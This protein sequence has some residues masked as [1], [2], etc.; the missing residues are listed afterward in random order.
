MRTF[1]TSISREQWWHFNPPSAGQ[2]VLRTFH[3]SNDELGNRTQMRIC[4]ASHRIR[5]QFLVGAFLAV[6]LFLIS[7]SSIMASPRC[8]S[9]SDHRAVASLEEFLTLIASLDY[10]SAY[11]LV[12]S[13]AKTKSDVRIEEMK[14]TE[15]LFFN[16]LEFNEERIE[17]LRVA[18]AEEKTRRE[19]EGP[20][21]FLSTLESVPITIELRDQE[22]KRRRTIKCKDFRIGRVKELGPDTILIHLTTKTDDGLI[23]K[24]EA[25]LVREG[26]RWL[27]ANPIHIIR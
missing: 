26:G 15:K 22:E 12:A 24:D 17:K 7:V 21:D 18:L 19:K 6:L 14:V 20:A 5:Y 13:V 2:P 8:I 23:D 4:N 16:E 11:T 9:K 25:I 10:A 27:I 3:V 1:T